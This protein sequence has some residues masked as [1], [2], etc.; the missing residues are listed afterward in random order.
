VFARAAAGA[1]GAYA[2]ARGLALDAWREVEAAGL[3]SAWVSA[4]LGGAGAAAVDG[5][6]VARVAGRHA[7]ALPVAET[8][9][10]GWLLA[11]AGIGVPEGPLAVVI[12]ARAQPQRDGQ[13]RFSAPSTR[14]AWARHARHAVLCAGSGDAAIVALLDAQAMQVAPG[15]SLAGEPRD[16]VVLSCADAIASAAP[17]AAA[18]AAAARRLG[19]L[20]RAQQMAGALERILEISLDYAR[21]RVQFGRPIARFQAVQQ[22]LARL[23]GE[24]AAAAAAAGAGASALAR[25]GLAHEIAARAAAAA[26]IRVGQAAGAGAAIAHQVHG[27]MGF[28]QEYV[29]QRYTRQLWS[30]RDDFGAETEWAQWLGQRVC[31][32]GAEAL[33]PELTRA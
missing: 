28:S 7:I 30:W 5:L 2:A 29:L 33:W 11:E 23:A 22:E 4:A 16:R 10:A 26:K 3:A 32:A 6:A 9:L 21:N 17:G 15:S 14:V 24:C 20:L 8:L 18:D 1:A 12:D 25:H 27:A 31:A 19:A 13:G